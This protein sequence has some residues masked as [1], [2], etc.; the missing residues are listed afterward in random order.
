MVDNLKRIAIIRI[1]CNMV[2]GIQILHWVN[3]FYYV[4][5]ELTVMIQDKYAS[6][7]RSYN[8]KNYLLPVIYVDIKDLSQFR[9]F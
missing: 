7:K 2:I 3:D 9:S 1:I 8:Q 5:L 4:K 6:L